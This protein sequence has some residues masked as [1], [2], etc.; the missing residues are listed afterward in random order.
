VTR[1]REI[2]EEYD[3]SNL[4]KKKFHDFN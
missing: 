2:I 3:L 1:I 4:L